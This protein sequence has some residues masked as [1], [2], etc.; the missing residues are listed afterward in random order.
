MT[1]NEDG[2]DFYLWE[3]G[4]TVLRNLLGA[5]ATGQLDIREVIRRGGVGAASPILV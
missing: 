3:T 2:W 5:H 4:G 1:G